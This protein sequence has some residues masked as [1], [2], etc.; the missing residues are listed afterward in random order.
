MDKNLFFAY[1]VKDKF[2]AQ[3]NRALFEIAWRNL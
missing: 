2:A 3:L 1:V